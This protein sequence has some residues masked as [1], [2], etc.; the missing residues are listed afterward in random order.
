MKEASWETHYTA[1]KSELLYPDE[2]LV[3]LLKK[4]RLL[5]SPGDL[6]A[7]DLGCGSGR[8]LR[9]LSDLGITRVIG[10]DASYNALVII[11]Q[12]VHRARCCRET[13]FTFR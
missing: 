6:T 8:H 4:N 13:T 5:G 2:N 7:V 10:L 12:T 3:R 11:P 1:G 9:L